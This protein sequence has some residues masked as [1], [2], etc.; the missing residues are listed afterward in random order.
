MQLQIRYIRLLIVSRLAWE[1]LS[2]LILLTD[3]TTW[4]IAA[5]HS[6][7]EMLGVPWSGRLR[8]VSSVSTVNEPHAYLHGHDCIQ[9]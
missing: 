6:C 3:L 8:L 5:Q 4:T 7:S 9:C 1:E 2:L